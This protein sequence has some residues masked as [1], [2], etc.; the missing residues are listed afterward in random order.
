[1]ADILYAKGYALCALNAVMRF[2]RA[3]S[4]G[5]AVIVALSAPLLI[6]ATGLSVDIGY[7]FQNQTSLQSAADSAALAAAMNDSRL[8]QTTA[9]AKASE[10]APY[11]QAAAD[12]ATH[13]Q[14]D[15]AAASSNTN[16]AISVSC[17]SARHRAWRLYGNHNVH[18]DCTRAP[19]EFFVA[20]QRFWARWP[21]CRDAICECDGGD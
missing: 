14:F 9:A 17:C 8:A 10:S 20:D 5:V 6:A 3:R 19:A 1:M 21:A 11:A 18:G 13:S 7:W 15:F 2:F 16:P 4:A 12:S